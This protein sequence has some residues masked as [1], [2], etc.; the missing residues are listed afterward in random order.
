MNNITYSKINYIKTIYLAKAKDES[1][2][3]GNDS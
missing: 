1:K 3:S 2:F